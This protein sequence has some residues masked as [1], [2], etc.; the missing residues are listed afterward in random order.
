[1][2][3]KYSIDKLEERI[4]YVFRDKD[5]LRQALTHSSYANE[6]KINKVKDYERIEFL[7]DAVLEMISSEYLYNSRSEMS[8]GQLTRTRAAMVCEPSLAACA[9]DLSLDRYILLGKGEE[10]TGG[11]SRDSIISDVME[12]LIGAVYLDGGFERAREFIHRFVLSDLE[13]KALFYDAKSILQEEMQKDGGDI[14]YVLVGESGPEH[15]KSFF[16]EVYQGDV[17][18]GSGSGHNKKAAQQ[19]AAYEALLRLKKR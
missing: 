12:A 2:D 16:V 10:M 15:D 9:R 1:M 19:K 7:G 4:G 14:R 17:L 13:D 3:E 18:L 6:R 5:L 11:R 8:E